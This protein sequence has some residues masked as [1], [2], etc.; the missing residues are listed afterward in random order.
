MYRIEVPAIGQDNCG[1]SKTPAALYQAVPVTSAID[2]RARC[3]DSGNSDNGRSEAS[4]CLHYAEALMI[5][6][7][8]RLLVN[9]PGFLLTELLPDPLLALQ[10][11]IDLVEGARVLTAEGEGYIAWLLIIIRHWSLRHIIYLYNYI[12]SE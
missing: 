8:L 4:L 9:L 1:K 5:I 2:V 12:F 3:D 6:E 10:Q 11:H 7:K